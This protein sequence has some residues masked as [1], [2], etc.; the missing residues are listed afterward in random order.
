MAGENQKIEAAVVVREGYIDPNQAKTRLV[1]FT[2]DGTQVDLA[3]VLTRID[4]LENPT[5]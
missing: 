2:E 4:A 3:D 1:L 5:P